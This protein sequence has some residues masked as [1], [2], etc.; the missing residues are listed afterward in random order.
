MA[1]SGG[2]R[3]CVG[4]GKAIMPMT[5][6]SATAPPGRQRTGLERTSLPGARTLL[7]CLALALGTLAIYWQ[8]L[9]HEFVDF[10]DFVSKTPDVARGLTP[11]GARWAFTTFHSANWHP[12]TWLSHMADVTLFG[13]QAGPHALVSVAMHAASAVLLFLLLRYLTGSLW[14]SAFVASLFAL[15]PLHVES[16]AWIAER[17]DVLSTFLGMLALWAYVF[18]THRPGL[19]RYLTVAALLVL[20]LMAKPML[21]TLPLLMLLLDYWPLGRLSPARGRAGAARPVAWWRLV[22]EKAP[23]LVLSVASG[24]MTLWAQSAGGAVVSRELLP[25]T[26]R[27]AN[28]VVAYVAYLGKMFWPSPLVF[29]YPHRF[30]PPWW[31]WAGAA[32]I[33]AAVTALA[34]ALARTR[35]YLI[36]GWLWYLVTLLPVI[37]IVQ[38]GSQA[39]ADRYTYV[40]LVG[41]FVAGA[42]LVAD[43]SE[44]WSW[45]FVP[46]GVAGAGVLVACAVVT[47]GQIGYWRSSR[48]LFEHALRVDQRN[49]IAHYNYGNLLS[50]EAQRLL[51]AGHPGAQEL[52]GQAAEHYREAALISPTMY[53]AWSNLGAVLVLQGRSE[54]ALPSLQQAVRGHPENSAA[55]HNLGEALARLG[56]L[57]EAAAEFEAALRFP[58]TTPDLHFSYA[59]VLSRQGKAPA[60][61]AQ[62]REALRRNPDYVESLWLLAR[63]LATCPDPDVRNGPQAVTLA[64][65]AVQLTNRRDARMLD[66]LA[67]AYA[68]TGRFDEAVVIEQQAIDLAAASG[69]DSLAQEA[70]RRMQLYRARQPYREPPR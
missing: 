7:V 4:P 14:R 2:P 5:R 40:P 3:S 50:A 45:R 39:I 20:G 69:P 43:L 19:W 25:P 32:A 17:K 63:L 51:A 49:H 9:G 52:L 11:E 64:E 18:Y 67:A 60:A 27:L 65:R 16:V 31:Q 41:I 21:V 53:D 15:H 26:D 30:A 35:P 13:L 28:A 6:E 44:R 1:G 10:D 37:G 56:R 55:R 22:L 34:V 48:A 54:E 29:F 42:W 62:Y 61:A 66:T 23:L 8:V 12:L 47:Y 36:V 57:D 38:V 46:L 68:E 58:P 24:A 70:A 33:L 59:R